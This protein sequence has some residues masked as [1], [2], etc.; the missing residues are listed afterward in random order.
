MVKVKTK[1]NA[2]DV[3]KELFKARLTERTRAINVRDGSEYAMQGF[4]TALREVR[5]ELSTIEKVEVGKLLE[6]WNSGNIK[7]EKAKRL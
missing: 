1:Y 3:I 5:G 7:N 2:T 6:A 4:K